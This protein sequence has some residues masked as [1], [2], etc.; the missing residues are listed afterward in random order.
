VKKSQGAV[1]ETG[2]YRRLFAVLAVVFL[3]VS[4][5]GGVEALAPQVEADEAEAAPTLDVMLVEPR[6]LKDD[7]IVPVARRQPVVERRPAT[8]FTA[9]T[10][11]A[12]SQVVSLFRDGGRQ[13]ATHPTGPPAVLV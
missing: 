11:P 4:L 2:R 13:R 7:G 6:V 3:V 9:A 1:T 10:R 5:I 8:F 12:D